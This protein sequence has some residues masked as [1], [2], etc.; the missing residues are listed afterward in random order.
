MRVVVIAMRYFSQASM[1]RGAC[2]GRAEGPSVDC[3]AGLPCCCVNRHESLLL[4]LLLLLSM[5]RMPPVCTTAAIFVSLIV[6]KQ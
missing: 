1:R 3:K 2:T 6:F 5:M 4:L